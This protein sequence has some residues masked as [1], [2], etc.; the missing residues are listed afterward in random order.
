MKLLKRF[1]KPIMSQIDLPSSE[2]TVP[3]IMITG[4]RKI[5]IEQHYKLL[6]FSDTFITLQCQDSVIQIKGHSFIIKFMYPNELIL[7]GFIE[8]VQFTQV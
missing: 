8:D 7:E 5:T 1:L 6:S 4:D 3:T 2:L